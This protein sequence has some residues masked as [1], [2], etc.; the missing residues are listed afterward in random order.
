MKKVLSFT[1][2]IVT[3]LILSD[4]SMRQF[5]AEEVSTYATCTGSDITF[6][7]RMYSGANIKYWISSSNEYVVSIPNAANKLMYPPSSVGTN[8]L[9]LSKT[10]TNSSSKMD[11][12]Q[13]SS[14]DGINAYTQNFRKNSSGKYYAMP[15][16][17]W[18]KYEWIYSEIRINDK[19]MNN[20]TNDQR[21]GIILHEML[22]GYG[23]KNINKSSSIMH[24]KSPVGVTKMTSDANNAINSKY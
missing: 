6:N 11:F 5:N 10:T 14:S 15:L 12:Y 23:L 2:I 21:S 13:Y 9:Y 17:E 8:P 19:Y 7:K 3:F 24:C 22:H 20:Y 1:F 16:S 18:E 4:Y